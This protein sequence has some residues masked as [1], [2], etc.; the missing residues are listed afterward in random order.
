MISWLQ[1]QRIENW[2]QSQKQGIVLACSGIGYEIQLLPSYLSSIC[3]VNELTLWI[4]QVK[5]EDAEILYGFH[6][7]VERDLFRILIGVSGVGPQTAM[8]LLEESQ[9]EGIVSAII[10]EDIC[11]LT[12]AQ[13][14][15]KRTAERLSIELRHKL[16]EFNNITTDINSLESEKILDLPFKNFSINNLQETL[17][18]LGYEDF[19]ILRAIRA[20]TDKFP[21]EV[22]KNDPDSTKSLKNETDLLKASLIWLSNES[23]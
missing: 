22:S 1:G 20:V 10:H 9:V 5:R 3:T 11:T 12:K 4:H 15:G 7:K 14:V 23:K 13:G 2:Q 17:Q 21:P 8:A 6:T 18:S 19:E 16:T